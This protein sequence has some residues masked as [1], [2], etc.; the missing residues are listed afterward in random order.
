MSGGSGGILSLVPLI[1][2]AWLCLFLPWL[3][4]I[5]KTFLFLSRFEFP[6]SME[7]VLT[8]AKYIKN[9]PFEL[10]Y[11]YFLHSK[12]WLQVILQLLDVMLRVNQSNVSHT[13]KCT[14]FTRES[15][16]NAVGQGVS[17]E[18]EF[19]GSSQGTLQV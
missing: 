16:K 13:L 6:L 2:E 4:E 15:Y 12:L 17:R 8:N 18:F 11:N 7:S 10:G 14:Q 5:S 19:P 3:A 9:T 1:F